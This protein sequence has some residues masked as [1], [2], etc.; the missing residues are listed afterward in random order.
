MP[1]EKWNSLVNSVLSNL[2][3]V[4]ERRDALRDRLRA[5]GTLGQLYSEYKCGGDMTEIGRRIRRLAEKA[6][7]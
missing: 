7:S 3:P 1:D 4:D 2:E 5:D 6:R